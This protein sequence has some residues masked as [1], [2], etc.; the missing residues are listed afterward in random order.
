MNNKR[1]LVVG[2]SE[3]EERY[4]N[5]AV[6]LLRAYNH[7]IVALGV[8]SGHI[9]TVQISTEINPSEKFDTVTIYVNPSLQQGY[10]EQIL[11]LKPNR[12]IFNPGT[13]NPEFE[14]KLKDNNI[15]PVEACTLVMLR[16]NQF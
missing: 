6:K 4:S 3:N 14:K 9:D 15:E 8:K 16:T 12:V 5:K 2:A 1:T 11:A 7:D 10:Y 13:E